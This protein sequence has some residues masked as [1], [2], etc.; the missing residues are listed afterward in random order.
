MHIK[1]SYG[2]H[3]ISPYLTFHPL[4]Q[5]LGTFMAE[6]DESLIFKNVVP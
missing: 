6:S 1:L 5:G 2:L 4:D 3:P